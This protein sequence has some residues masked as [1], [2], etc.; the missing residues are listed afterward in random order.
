MLFTCREFQL[1]VI[2]KIL[3]NLSFLTLTNVRMI[4]N[5]QQ[6]R[7]GTELPFTLNFSQE[8]FCSTV[9]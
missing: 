7:W 8:D 5:S 1:C 6:C 3:V 9:L 2:T 4:G